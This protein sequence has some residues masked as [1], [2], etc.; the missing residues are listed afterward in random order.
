MKKAVI[1]LLG[2]IG[3][4]YDVEKKEN[5]LNEYTKP[6]IY[7]VDKELINLKNNEYINILLYVVQNPIS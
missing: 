5:I 2:L 1:T 7:N 6:S 4:K 3:T